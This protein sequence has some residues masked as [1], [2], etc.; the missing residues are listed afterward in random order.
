MSG[1]ILALDPGERR[2]GVAVSDATCTIASP[3]EYIDR[4]AGDHLERVRVLCEEWEISEI[5]VGLPISLD[6]TEGPSAVRSREFAEQVTEATGLPVALHD[7]RFTTLTAQKALIEGGV[8]RR[9]RKRKVDKI[10]AAI[11]LQSYL[12]RRSYDFGE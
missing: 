2:I 11:T 8:T 5:I 12:E 1:R 3:V 9:S 7:E 4:R 10:A 6:G